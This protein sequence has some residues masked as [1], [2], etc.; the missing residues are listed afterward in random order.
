MHNAKDVEG[1]PVVAIADGKKLGTVDELVVSPDEL[2][3]LGFVMKSGLFGHRELVVE[4]GDI[5]AFGADAITIDSEDAARISDDA[6]AEFGEARAAGRRITGSKVVT[7][8]GSLIGS[9][10]DFVIDERSLR[11]TTLLLGGSFMTGADAIPT[12]RVISVGPDM[13][14]VADQADSRPSS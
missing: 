5:R 14:V 1:M 4:A 11:I 8:S 7:E 9:V 3:L 13:I 6:A 2:R 12:N 10:S